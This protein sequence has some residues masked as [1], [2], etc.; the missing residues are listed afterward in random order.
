MLCYI[1]ESP[2]MSASR[3][4]DNLIISETE[5][6]LGEKIGQGTFGEVYRGEWQG[7]EVAVKVIKL[8]RNDLLQQCKREIDI[9]RYRRLHNVLL[10]QMQ[11]HELCVHIL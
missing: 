3:P 4:K 2:V 8:P 9:L 7:T 1:D 6:T 10:N 5:V 11:L